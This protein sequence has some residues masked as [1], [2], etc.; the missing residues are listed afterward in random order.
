[1]TKLSLAQWWHYRVLKTQQ[2]VKSKNVVTCY[3]EMS[4]TVTN[5][6]GL[7]N[8]SST[9]KCNVTTRLMQFM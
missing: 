5:S 2:F 9:E 7:N 6:A 1:M 3:W 4:L 8:F